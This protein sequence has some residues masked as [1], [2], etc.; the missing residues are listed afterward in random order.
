[1]SRPLVI[2]FGPTAVGKTEL[3]ERLAASFPKLEIVNAD[4]MQVYR[5]L[6]IGT[7]KPA[8]A[9]RRAIPHHLIDIVDPDVQ[10]DAGQFVRRAERA[11]A[12]I[13]A[14]GGLP[15]LC[16]GT[17]YY[18]RSFICGLA[19]APASDPL[20]RRQLK[21][22]LARRGPEALLAELARVDPVT[23]A[24]VAEADAYRMLRAL[25][26]YRASG[27]PLSSFANPDQPRSDYTF[28]TLGLA[29]ERAELYRRINARVEGMFAA[30]LRR[31]VAGLLARGYG[32]G[33]PGLRGIGYREFFLMQRG[34]WT[35]TDLSEAIQRDS[36]RFAK[37]QITFFKSLP[38]VEWLPASE[39]ERIGR[40]IAEF[41]T[42]S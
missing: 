12:E 27:R 13:R 28:L 25:E 16:G 30:G 37:R 19:Q 15:L 18:L 26:V 42:A 14:R 35:L 3:V 7:A 2:L 24:S 21:E 11:V 23:R 29:R 33:D 41:L 32:P 38:S 8:A 20:I 22:E 17:A 5:Y 31:E 36:R 1:L 39:L 10:F 4:S 9:L 34:C 40:R 6:D